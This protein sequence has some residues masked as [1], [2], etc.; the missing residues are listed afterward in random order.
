MSTDATESLCK[1]I[2]G[3]REEL[4]E[5]ARALIAAVPAFSRQGFLI[6]D[7][8]R[9]PHMLEQFTIRLLGS[10][11]AHGERERGQQQHASVVQVDEQSAL[12]Q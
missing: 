11:S 6:R 3:R 9:I 2:D 8:R 10:D 5:L 12:L 1:S 7:S 4:V